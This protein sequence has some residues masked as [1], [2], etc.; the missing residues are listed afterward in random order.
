MF[1]NTL[2]RHE[3]YNMNA[4]DYSKA[5]KFRDFKGNKNYN[6]WI[7]ASFRAG[8]LDIA[9]LIAHLQDRVASIVSKRINP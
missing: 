3:K 5:G 8:L 7:T 9:Y 2:Y 4:I 1:A 6:I